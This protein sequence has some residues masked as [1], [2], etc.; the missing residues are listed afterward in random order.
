MRAISC[1][2]GMTREEVKE[3]PDEA[4]ESLQLDIKD[5]LSMFD[6]VDWSIAD[7]DAHCEKHKPGY[8]YNRPA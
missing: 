6:T 3:L 4:K 2:T 8:N 1:Y 7:I 5:N